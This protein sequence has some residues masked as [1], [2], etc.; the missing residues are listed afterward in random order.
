MMKKL[1][2][3]F[4]IFVIFTASLVLAGFEYNQVFADESN[5]FAM[6][7]DISA[8]LTFKFRDGVERQE[9]AVLK[10]TDFVNGKWVT[11]SANFMDV[12]QS[13]SFQSFDGNYLDPNLGTSFQVQGVV[14]DLPHLHKALDEAYKFRTSDTV[15]YN[16]KFF[17]IDVEFTH[18]SGKYDMKNLGYQA[19]GGDDVLLPEN[20]EPR[21]TLHYTNCQVADYVVGTQRNGYRS[22]NIQAETGFAIVET[23]EFQCSGIRSDVASQDVLSYKTSPDKINDFDKSDYKYAEDIRTFVTFEFDNGLEKIEFP[24]FNLVSGFGEDDDPSFHVEGVVNRY[25][26]LSSAIDSAR[27]TRNIPGGP[28]TDFDAKV[29]FIQETSLGDKVLRAINYQDCSI[30]GS[31]ITTYYENEEIY[32]STGG[33]GIMQIID[34]DCGGMNPLNPR[35]NANMETNEQYHDYNMASGPQATSIFK[36][37]DNTVETIDFPIFRHQ[38]IL[39]KSNVVFQLEGMVGDYPLLYKQVDDTAKINQITGV[40]QAHELFDMDVNLMYEDNI[41]RGFYYS[42]CR[43]IDYLISTEHQNEEGFWKGFAIVNTFE[44]ECTGYQPKDTM[45]DIILETDVDD[46]TTTWAGHTFDG[47]LQAE[48]VTSNLTFTFRDGIETH[49]FPVFKTTSDHAENKGTSFQVQGVVSDT[50]HLHKALD[51]AYKY[52][53]AKTVGGFDYN[54][55]FFDVDVVLANNENSRKIFY[56]RDCQVADYVVDTLSHTHRGYLSKD[57]GFAIVYTIDFDCNGLHSKVT[58]ESDLTYRTEPGLIKEFPKLEYNHADNIR[59]WVMFGFEN[60]IEK[61]EFPIFKT[62]SGFAENDDDSGFYVEG[63]ENRYPLLNSAID[64]AR[65][66]RNLPVGTNVDF[67]AIAA[68]VQD[69]P[70]G[71]KLIR[72]IYYEDCQVKGSDVTT[73]YDKEEPFALV[74]GFAVNHSIDFS[75]VKM[76]PLNPNYGLNRVTNEQYYDYNMASGIHAISEFR[77]HDNTIEIIDFPIFKQDQVLSKLEPTFRLMGL[78]GDYPL[79]YKQVDIA[80]KNNQDIGVSLADELFDVDVNLM[81]E[82]KKIRE[83]SYSK[84]R[85]VDYEVATQQGNEEGFFFWFALE[86]TFEFECSGYHPK[87]PSYDTTLEIDQPKQSNNKYWQDT[88]QWSDEFRYIPRDKSN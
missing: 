64:N 50:P 18:A 26:L 39:S 15:N 37:H 34:F 35:Y 80:A 68:F 36:Y 22:Y 56:Y 10:T 79:L 55:K 75:C 73:Y 17:D 45:D 20:V 87:N 25:P 5:G 9:F 2:F 43:V 42:D 88:Q 86:N 83:F 8:H 53:S 1:Q 23:I 29:E 16:Y 78:V 77:F 61:I 41:V 7:E 63:I 12:G 54:Y 74:G 67:K 52:R 6:A 49:E 62:T 47:F 69:T 46:K 85:V 30:E 38:G 3:I 32:L 21:K 71:E 65:D 19:V 11:N 24:F 66:N 14:A 70:E 57:T 27:D 28:N 31:A 48:N 4:G 51:E 40:T 44:F 76:T 72:G 33:A 84:C 81:K 60:G 82:D 58:S 59:T 13:V